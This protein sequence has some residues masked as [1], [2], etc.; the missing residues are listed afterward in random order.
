[1]TQHSGDFAVT[2]KRLLLYA[3]EVRHF[4]GDRLAAHPYPLRSGS[5]NSLV[6]RGVWHLDDGSSLGLTIRYTFDDQ[7]EVD[8]E[9][10]CRFCEGA[11]DEPLIEADLP[12][13]DAWRWHHLSCAYTNLG[14]GPPRW[15]Q[16]RRHCPHNDRVA[17]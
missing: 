2:A 17:P 4:Q 10:F 8:V 1:M 5:S 13:T 16:R 3:D 15:V 11:G 12:L 14:A 6:R 9:P 7:L